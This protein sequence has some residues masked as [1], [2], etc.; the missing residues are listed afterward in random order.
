MRTIHG[1][2]RDAETAVTLVDA[3]HHIW[4][5]KRNHY[6]WLRDLPEPAFFLVDYDAF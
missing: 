3:H 6:P 1:S 2:W 4:D 5:L